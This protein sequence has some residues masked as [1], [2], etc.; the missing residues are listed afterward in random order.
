MGLFKKETKIEDVMQ[1]IPEAKNPIMSEGVIKR[2][3]FFH[4]C[5]MS[6][7]QRRPD[8]WEEMS[9]IELYICGYED[10]TVQPEKEKKDESVIL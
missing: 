1:S 10:P 9:K 6:L 7:K 3:S 2:D 5:W 8:L 4:S